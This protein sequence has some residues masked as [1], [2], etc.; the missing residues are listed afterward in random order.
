MNKL[1]RLLLGLLLLLACSWVF[2]VTLITTAPAEWLLFQA[3]QGLFGQQVAQNTQQVAWQKVQGT[4]SSG[5]A[6]RLD[7]TGISLEEVSWNL[8]TWRLALANPAIN[9][10]VGSE[11]IAAGALESKQPWRLQASL[12]PWGRLIANLQAG[13]LAL[14]KSRG[15]PWA[16]EGEL[17]GGLNLNAKLAKQGLDCQQLSGNLTG[18]IKVLQPLQLELGQ[19]F[20]QPTCPDAQ[21]L[22]WLLTAEQSGQHKLT[23]EGQ[24]NAKTRRWNFTAQAKLEEPSK[25]RP[26]LQMLGWRRDNQGNLQAKASGGF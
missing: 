5:S 11:E 6:Q 8:S 18:P 19:V 24:A 23:L 1:R 9:L 4:L 15:L 13:D 21:T 26:A 7:L 12:L 2:L 25:L 16:L 3:Q 22:D 10:Q 17:V 20:L 14:L